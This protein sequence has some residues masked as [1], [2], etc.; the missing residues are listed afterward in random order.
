VI[1]ALV[2]GRR[3]TGRQIGAAVRETSRLL[4][5]GGWEV[6]SAVVGHKRTLRHRAAD[7]AKA[8]LDV[9]VAVGGDGAVFQVV[10]AV[11]GTPAVVGI[12]PKGTGNLLAT[13]LDI[14]RS[15]EKAVEVLLTGEP[16]LIDLGRVSIGGADHDFAVACGIGFDAEVMDSTNATTK[17]RWGKLAYVASAIRE[18]RKIQEADY[19]ITIDGVTTDTPA[20]QVFIANFGRVGAIVEPRRRIIPDDGLLDVIVARASGPLGGLRAGWEALVQRQLGQAGDGRVFRTR[21]REV[22]VKAYP[23]QLVEVDGSVIGRTPIQV[24]IRPNGLKVIAPRRS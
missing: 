8:G 6:E 11:A 15:L 17:R 14:P 10:N 16:R 2:I 13:N 3:R 4:E 1:R 23:R 7:A 12:V 9:V 22:T 20:A 24:S 5:L 19:E 18:G 21:A